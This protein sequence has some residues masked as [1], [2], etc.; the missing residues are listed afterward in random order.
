MS[1]LP[2]NE[3]FVSQYKVGYKK[4]LNFDADKIYAKMKKHDCCIYTVEWF[5]GT[6]LLMNLETFREFQQYV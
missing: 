2:K 5:D 3:F 1:V 4:Q 6:M